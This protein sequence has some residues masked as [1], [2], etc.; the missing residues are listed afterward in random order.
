ML[1][2][3][4]LI[5][6][7]QALAIG[8]HAGSWWL[9]EQ[10]PGFL[11][12]TGFLAAVVGIA[13][14]GSM[15]W[16]T[17]LVVPFH[18]FLIALGLYHSFLLGGRWHWIRWLNAIMALWAEMSAALCVYMALFVLALNQLGPRLF[19]DDPRYSIW[20]SNISVASL[21]ALALFRPLTLKVARDTIQLVQRQR[22]LR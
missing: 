6:L 16:P 10:A 2:L 20:P 13:G 3:L 19:A 22:G 11:V 21:F 4:L 15:G 18:L 14:I 9:R 8:I 12:G 7:G 5:L 1:T 17:V